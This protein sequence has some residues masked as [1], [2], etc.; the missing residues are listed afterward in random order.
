MLQLM[1]QVMYPAMNA[2]E[3][4]NLCTISLMTLLIS[5][6]LV[7]LISRKPKNGCFPPGSKGWPL[8][9]ES[10]Q[11]V[12]SGPQ[13]FI[14]KRM[15]KYSPYVF[16]SALFGEKMAVFCGPEGNKVLFTNENKLVRSWWPMSTRKPLYSSEFADASTDEIA[17]VLMTF[18]HDILKM[19]VIKEYIPVMDTMARE[20]VTSKWAAKEVVKVLPASKEY[21]FNLGCRFLMNVVDDERVTTLAKHFVPVANG[22]YSVPL[23][24]PGTAYNRAIQSGKLL[25]EELIKIITERRNAMLMERSVIG[26]DLLS[27]LLL[28][29]DENGKYLSA[30]H[31]CNNIIGLLLASY[32]TSGNAITFVLK[33]LAEL[34]HIYNEVYKGTTKM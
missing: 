12:L 23:E 3:I 22:T 10:I 17:A 20:H 32:E 24:L 6:V 9:G 15:E 14:K 4:M 25:R 31:I 16:Q 33:Y 13:K 1:N 30:K 19:D 26:Q 21:A 29:T 8:V 34:P 18:L 11:Y 2:V 5:L 28:I 7:F 27:R